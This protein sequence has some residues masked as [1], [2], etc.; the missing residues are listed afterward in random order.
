MKILVVICIFLSLSVF[1]GERTIHVSHTGGCSNTIER[2]RL[3]SLTQKS[4]LK[5]CAEEDALEVLYY[6]CE[7]EKAG[8][9]IGHTEPV[10][11]DCISQIVWGGRFMKCFA[12]V[13]GECLVDQ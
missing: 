6:K 1:A 2:N 10:A 13:S 4:K 9:L 3:G 8:Q 11:T 12:E 7:T 5:A